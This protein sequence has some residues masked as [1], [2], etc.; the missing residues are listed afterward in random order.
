MSSRLEGLRAV[1]VGGGQTE[2]SMIGNGRAMA[3]TFAREGAR[4]LVVD[5]SAHAGQATVDAIRERGGEAHLHVSD[6]TDESQVSGLSE[7][8]ADVFGGLDILVN[9]VGIVLAGATEDLPLESWR[10]VHDVNVT[11]MWLT[12]KHLL[13]LMREQG[14][15]AVINISSMASFGTT[16][17][18]IAY[19]TSK[20]TVNALTRTLAVEYAPHGVRVNAIAPGMVDTP[21][22]VDGEAERTQRTR[23]QVVAARAA[24]VPM[25]FLGTGWD[26]ANAALFLASPEARWVTGVILPVDGGSSVA[27]SHP[28]HR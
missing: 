6:I 5:H 19:T 2:G 21:M 22:G 11:A 16:A 7:A 4:V 8:V 15:G 3:E 9:N 23:E 14:A 27:M 28:V 20:A 24:L 26:I 18:N 12:A 10:R 25:G 1:V 13:P 17:S